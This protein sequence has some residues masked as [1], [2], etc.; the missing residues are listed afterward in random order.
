MKPDP[1]KIYWWAYVHANRTLQLKRW[2]G[3]V[4]DYTDDCKDNPFVEL[5]IEPF[6]A[7]TREEA[8]IIANQKVLDAQIA[9]RKQP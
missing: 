5:V 4:K 9:S 6:E 1:N 7:N 2:F 8:F 3:D